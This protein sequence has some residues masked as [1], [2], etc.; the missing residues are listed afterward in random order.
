MVLVFLGWQEVL[1]IIVAI[2]SRKS[3]FTGTGDSVEN[4][5]QICKEYFS[6]SQTQDAEFVIYEDEGFSGKNTNRPMFQKMLSDLKH[7]RIQIVMCYRLDR[8]SRNV[9]DFSNLLETLKQY[10]VDFIS[11][12]ENFDTSS[13]MGRAMVYISSVFAQLERETIAERVKDNKLQIARGGRWQGGTPPLGYHPVPSS[14]KDSD[15]KNRTVYY[16]EQAEGSPEIQSVKCLFDLYTSYESLSKAGQMII[17]QFP[18]ISVS[19]DPTAIRQILSNPVYARNDPCVFD[20]LQGVGCIL[21]NIREEFDG[22]YGLIGYG[23]TPLSANSK[24]KRQ[25]IDHWMIAVGKHQPVVS[26]E[27]WVWVLQSLQKNRNHA[28]RLQTSK[29]ALCSGI[30]HCRCGAKMVV[31]GNR[32]DASGAI[33]FYYKCVEKIR[34]RG[35][36]CNAPNLQGNQFDRALISKLEALCSNGMPVM[37]F[38]DTESQLLTET[39]TREQTDLTQHIRANEQMTTN[40]SGRLSSPGIPQLLS[41]SLKETILQLTQ[42]TA[43]L[44]LQ[45]ETAASSSSGLRNPVRSPSL[46]DL[47]HENKKLLLT[48]IITSIQWDGECFRVWL[49]RP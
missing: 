32:V 25:T 42:E 12:R 2:Y 26:G 48:S 4:Q 23:K 10:Q 1:H 16:L 28:P 49:K 19:S 41:A 46:A 31:K 38:P 34:S 30:L 11:V 43:Q 17:Q 47:S 18:S 27:Q 33:Q 9:S 39:L 22:K 15:E 44:K 8:L 5:V 20:Y 45:L 35:A 36:I 40:L 24:R 6:L 3:K 14:R 29:T 7:G 21:P 37:Q 13:P